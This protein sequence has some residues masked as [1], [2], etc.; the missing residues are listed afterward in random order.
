MEECMRNLEKKREW[1]RRY[2]ATSRGRAVRNAIASRYRERNPDKVKAACLL[3]MRKI[4]E[5]DPARILF[6]G[7]KARAKRLGQDFSIT[8]EDVLI[9]DVCPVLGIKLKRNTGGHGFSNAS[10]TI[11]RIDSSKGYI[12]GNVAVISGRA[13]RVKINATV[14]E[15]EAILAYMKGAGG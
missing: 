9:P 14:A 11:D 12:K 4:R 8:I 6:T 15:M 2:R 13:N 5:N 1:E 7:A 3:S 10:P